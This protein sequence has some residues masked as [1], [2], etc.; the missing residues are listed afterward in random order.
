MSV[1]LVQRW[2]LARLRMPRRGVVEGS[3]SDIFG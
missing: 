3:Q 1:L 2:I